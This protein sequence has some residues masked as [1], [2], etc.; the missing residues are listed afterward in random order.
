[1][2]N[3]DSWLVYYGGLFI[4]IWANTFVCVWD[5]L[6]YS[7]GMKNH[8]WQMSF[9]ESNVVIWKKIHWQIFDFLVRQ[10]FLFLNKPLVCM[11][12]KNLVMFLRRLKMRTRR[13]VG[14]K[15]CKVFWIWFN[16]IIWLHSFLFK[17]HIS[18][19][20]IYQHITKNSEIMPYVSAH[21]T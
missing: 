5:I 15:E 21:I 10:S 12:A 20:W 7:S 16:E 8:R 13:R 11:H 9:V 19:V 6:A 4:F 3:L 14:L 1:M 18:C 17:F 2:C